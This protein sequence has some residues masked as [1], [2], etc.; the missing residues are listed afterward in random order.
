MHW[1][2]TN[3]SS[4]YY[5]TE[6]PITLRQHIQSDWITNE[7]R[8]PWGDV[9]RTLSAHGYSKLWRTSLSM[10]KPTTWC[11]SGRV[12]LVSSSC[13]YKTQPARA[14]AQVCHTRIDALSLD[15]YQFHLLLP[16]KFPS[17]SSNISKVIE[18]LMNLENTRHT[19]I[20]PTF[21]GRV[22]RTYIWTSSLWYIHEG[23]DQDNFWLKHCSIC[24]IFYTRCFGSKPKLDMLTARCRLKSPRWPS[25][26]STHPTMV[27]PK[28]ISWSW[29]DDSHPFHSMSISH[30]I[31]EVRLFQTLIK[32]QGQ[33][34]GCG[35]RARSYDRPS[36]LLIR[37]LFISHQWDQQFLW[38]SYFEIWPSKIPGQ[39]DKWGQ[40]SRSQIIPSIQ[41]MHFL[42]ISHQSDQPFLRYD[43][44]SVWPWK[45][46]SEIFKE[47]LQKKVSNRLYPKFN[48]EISMTRGI[49]LI[50]FVVIGWVIGWVVLTLWSR[51]ENFC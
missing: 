22:K 5:F 13:L 4:I 40:R 27:T 51:Q 17:L 47:N 14:L 44:K 43:Q 41:P 26:T 12:S 36:I 39:G 45:N 42:F 35:Q 9:L 11:K 30:P 32:L 50:Y 21:V 10:N 31:P 20:P 2:R 3:I 34:H 15:E 38:Y 16:P 29:M 24:Y 23:N 49:M 1:I 33:G 25:A 48:Q 8:K 19:I 46:T 18:S 37:L 28:S 7:P 6:I